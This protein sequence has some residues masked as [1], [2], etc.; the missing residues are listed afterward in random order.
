MEVA[1]QKVVAVGSGEE[2][3]AQVVAVAV[4][5]EVAVAPTPVKAEHVVLVT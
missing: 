2:V 1:E 5:D 4:A 3:A